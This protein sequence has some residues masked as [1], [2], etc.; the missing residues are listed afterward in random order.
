VKM[1]LRAPDFVIG[2]KDRPY[3]RRWWMIPRNRWFNVYLHEFLR[4][5]DDRALHDHPWINI[6]ILL[7]GSY[8]EHQPIGTVRLRKPWRPWAPWRVVFRLPSAAHR[9]ELFRHYGIAGT[10]KEAPVWTLF[11]TGPRVRPWGFWCPK[12]WVHWE[13]FTARGNSGEVGRGCDQ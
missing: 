5:D 13:D 3:L 9:I 12:G 10:F 7:R 2:G 4:S 11:I 1:A 8:L 6:S